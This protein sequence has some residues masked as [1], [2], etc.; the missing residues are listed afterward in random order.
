MPE[1]RVPM[2]RW[3][4]RGETLVASAGL[5]LAGV[6]TA[7]LVGAG[8][9]ALHVESE[10]LR[11]GETERL[12]SV[13]RTLART[14]EG[15]LASRRLPLAR[16]TV[17]EVMALEGLSS[18]RV[19]LPGGAVL[20]EGAESTRSARGMPD[21]WP[22]GE[23]SALSTPDG[24][25]SERITLNIPRLG[26][27]A[28]DV[29]A[30]VPVRG[31]ADSRLALGLGVAGAAGLVGSL[32]AYRWMRRRVRGIGAV[33]EALRALGGGETSTGA[34]EVSAALGCEATAWNA[35]LAERDS[36]RRG[37]MSEELGKAFAGREGGGGSNELSAACD[38]LWL[39]LI[40]VDE[41][42]R[43]KYINGAA[44]AMLG[45]ER[46]CAGQEFG[47]LAPDP[48]VV[49]AVRG[50]STG[51]SRQR[52]SVEVKLEGDR[53]S[54]L[55]FTVRAMRKEESAAAMVLV[56]DVTQQRVAD[57]SRNSFVAQVTHELRTPLTNIRL[58]LDTLVDE[59]DADPATRAKCINVIGQEARRL[60]RVVADMLS[61]AEIEAGSFKVHTADVRLDALFEELAADYTAQATDKEIELKFDLPPKLPVIAGDRDKI[62][63]AL[64]NLVG[65]ALKYTPLGGKVTVKVEEST[66]QVL[67][68]VADNGIGVKPEECDLIFE[69][70]Y[71]AKDKRISSITGSGLGLAL[72][73]QVVRLHGGDVTV[74][75][76]I[77][78]GSTFTMSLPAAGGGSAVLAKAA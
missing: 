36:L 2:R 42:S 25:M 56:E 64:H 37:V 72:A 53:A 59:G 48:R 38:A 45:A 49:E 33:G 60:E 51:Q 57:E 4:P 23:F 11:Q 30:R 41:R 76:V 7:V 74:R 13:A 5:S 77:D 19:V 16:G 44:A 50:A 66:G 6:L 27:A 39:G 52:T 14:I 17:S 34:L 10:S 12:R 73:R 21:A 35:L 69:K 20:I 65:N 71:R 26:P 70:F 31:L 78:K 54:T 22:T 32:L 58:Y 15:D 29:S 28:L 24:T 67:F 46:E 9:W 61:V 63:L 18:C 1:S 62:A 43:V 3:L 47:A 40:L 75:S 8:A 68:H 55:R